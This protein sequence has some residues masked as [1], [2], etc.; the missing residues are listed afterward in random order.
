[1]G[2][3]AGWDILPQIVSLTPGGVSRT[4]G[5][6]SDATPQRIRW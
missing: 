3:V 4:E 1:M 5:T 6:C 2:P